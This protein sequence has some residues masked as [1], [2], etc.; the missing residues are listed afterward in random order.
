[1]TL[2]SIAEV[3]LIGVATPLTA[4]C[5]LP[6]YPA[7]I[8]SLAS[9]GVDESGSARS[10]L[11]L[12]LLVVSG[13]LVFVG[14]V[15][16]LFTTVLGIGVPLLAFAVLSEPFSQRV[17]GTLARYSDPMNRLLGGFFV[18]VAAYYLVFIYTQT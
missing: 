7:F 12:G 4:V 5:V 1:M 10:P 14:T 6:L 16:F 9:A 3:F 17:T 18:L 11:W 15:A 8:S 13:V 2:Q